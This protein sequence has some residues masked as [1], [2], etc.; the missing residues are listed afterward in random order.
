MKSKGIKNNFNNRKFYVLLITLIFS[1]SCVTIYSKHELKIDQLNIS[2]QPSF[3]TD[4]YYY[5]ER[6]SKD[7]LI[8]THN[9]TGGRSAVKTSEYNRKYVD[10]IIPYLNGYV[11]FASSSNPLIV[12]NVTQ[13][14]QL[15]SLNTYTN[16][17]GR[18]E[19]AMKTNKYLF[20]STGRKSDIWNWGI[21]YQKKDSIL[22]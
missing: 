10:I 19:V 16:I 22:I 5:F 9:K 20:K 3:R 14:V 11:S 7:Y 15:D 6:E 12:R 13:P 18:W 4:G 8:D 21:F 1:S 17:L 2:W